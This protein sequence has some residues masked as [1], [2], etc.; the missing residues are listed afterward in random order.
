M[1]LLTLE[2]RE[3]SWRRGAQI[4]MAEG[5]GQERELLMRAYRE[6]RPRGR[7]A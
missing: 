7:D 6:Q 1:R 2:V 5:R 4:W 3:A